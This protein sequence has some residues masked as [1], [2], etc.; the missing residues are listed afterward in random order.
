MT[1]PHEDDLAIIKEQAR[2]WVSLFEAGDVSTKEQASF[3]EWMNTS[4]QHVHEFCKTEQLWKDLSLVENYGQDVAAAEYIQAFS[5]RIKSFWQK[6][7]NKILANPQPILGN[8]KL[9]LITACLLAAIT[10][11]SLFIAE[12]PVQTTAYTTEYA[13]HKDIV[14]EDGSH[15]F[16]SARTQ[17]ETSFSD[18]VR[19][20][21]LTSGEAFFD[22][23]KDSDRPFIITVGTTEVFVTGTQFDIHRADDTIRVAVAE[24]T[25]EVTQNNETSETNEK[26]FLRANQ[27]I[28][29][30]ESGKISDV[31]TITG[32]KPGAWRSGRLSYMQHPLYSLV[33][34]LNRYYM[35]GVTVMDESLNSIEITTSFKIEQIEQM[36]TALA[37]SNPVKVEKT[38]EGRFIIK[39]LRNDDPLE[40]N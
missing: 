12:G 6:P 38:P 7:N 17:F 3:Q 30:T 31:L 24:G 34:D 22:I 25:V 16:L 23:A 11:T 19:H 8:F 32:N 15:I 20:A 18:G 21:S 40:N 35:P 37:A 39:A 4:P 28:V 27:H 29:A 1:A 5:E 10:I 36:M 9:V 33:S 13:E 14:L 2:F 26:R